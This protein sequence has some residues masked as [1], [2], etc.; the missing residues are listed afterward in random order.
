MAHRVVLPAKYLLLT[1]LL[2]FSTLLSAQFQAVI[3]AS[4]LDGNNG[5]ALNGVEAGDASGTSVGYAGDINFD[6]KDDLII[7]A[8]G[9]DTKGT[10]SGDSYVLFGTTNPNQSFSSLFLSGLDGNFGFAL[11][12]VAV[13]DASGT[14]VGYAGDIN[15]DGKDDLIIGAP[16]ADTKGTDSGDSYV[17]FGTTNPNLSLSSLFLSGLDGDIGFGLNGVA[18]GDAS[19][20][21]VGYAGDINNDGK[22]DLIIG[23]PG[24]DTKGTDSGDSYVLFGTTNPN[25]SLSSLFLSGL[26]GD[27]GFSLNGVAA[28]DRSGVSVSTVADIN[29]DG[30]DDL[31]IGAPN[32][33]SNGAGSG[34]I[35]ILFGSD[36]PNHSLS[37]LFLSGLDGSTG[38]KMNGVA[39]GDNFGSSVRFAG[40]MNDDGIDD[41]IVGAPGAG[42]NGVGSGAAYVLFGGINVN[43]N[44]PD[45]FLSNLNGVRGFKIN[46]VAA[47]DN[48]GI[49][50]SRA[51]DI[52]FDGVGDVIIGAPG[53]DTKGAG[54]GD[55]YVVYGKQNSIFADSFEE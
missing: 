50:V 40:D 30:I 47:G 13:G 9:A 55:S 49:S 28:G 22:D 26:D 45:Y 52:N 10:D 42:P 18:A 23:A 43:Q 5:F 38:F 44:F 24:A 11:N 14:S 17:L 41:L 12:G 25:L 36:N 4:A 7:G 19:G 35:Y 8:P 33:A 51:G 6:G 37:S 27:I 39:A 21:S 32:A 20:T 54:S 1:S 48:F 3:E 34:A 2:S 46:G 53:A 31:I 15:N 16:G 29:A